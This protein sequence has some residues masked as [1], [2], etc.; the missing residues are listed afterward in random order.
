V[1]NIIYT[2]YFSIQEFSQISRRYKNI[3][4]VGTLAYRLSI[5]LHIYQLGENI[6]IHIHIV[7]VIACAGS[8]AYITALIQ[9]NRT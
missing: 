5:N 2:I 9:Y 8:I 1:Y 4:N 6:H 7:L 3:Q